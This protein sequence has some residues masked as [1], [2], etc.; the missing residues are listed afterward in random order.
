MFLSEA[1]SSCCPLNGP[2]LGKI[3]HH[4]LHDEDSVMSY[5]EV[6]AGV[7]AAPSADAVPLVLGQPI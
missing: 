7:A 2:H 4:H 5:V 3:C 6:V 1:K